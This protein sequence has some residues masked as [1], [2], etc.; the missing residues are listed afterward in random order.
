MPARYWLFKS[1]PSSFS[2]DDLAR[3]PGKTTFWNGVRNYQARNMLRDQ[4]QKGD[5]V[6]FYHSNADP[7]AVAGLA[8]VT[9]GGYPDATQFDP[10]SDYHD[11]DA[12]PDDPRW[13]MVDIR[14]QEKFA[15][16]LPLDQLRTVAALDKMVL[17]QR[18]SRLSVQ[19][20]TPGEWKAI[21]ALGRRG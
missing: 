18:G 17:L 7:P 3:A 2:I 15:R 6:I 12:T 14:F 13:F 4:I 1:E 20:V 16:P 21:A 8:E 11:P 9:R 5:G 10:K 19:P